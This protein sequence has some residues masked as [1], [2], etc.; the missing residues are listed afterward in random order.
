MKFMNLYTIINFTVQYSINLCKKL[1]CL[2]FM[3]TDK[4]VVL[5]IIILGHR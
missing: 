1:S 4:L 3:I 2:V 5:V